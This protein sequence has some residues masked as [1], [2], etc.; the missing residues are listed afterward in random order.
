MEE[1]PH[2]ITVIDGV[3]DDMCTFEE[4]YECYLEAR[5]QKRYRK[6]VMEFTDRLEPNLFEIK[7]ELESQTYK[8]GKYSTFFIKDPKTRLIMSLKFK[9]RIVQWAIYRKLM[10]VY[11]KIFIDD[12][13]ACRKGKG[14]HKAAA[15]LQ[16]WLK[17]ASRK[18]GDW[19]ILKLDISKYF[20]RIDHAVLL[21][22][23]K[24]RIKDER[25]LWLL[26]QIIDNEN[27]RFG[28]PPGMGPEECPPEKR[29]A[30]RGMPIGNLTS[31]LFSNVYLNE[32]DQY[33][34]HTL[35][36]KCYERFADDI[37]IV[38]EDKKRLAYY[39]DSISTFLKERLHLDLNK[40]KTIIC[41][42]SHGVE[43]VGFRVYATHIKLKKQT[44]R[45][46][47]RREKAMNRGISEGTFSIE[48][49][50]RVTASSNGLMLYCNSYG[51]RR[52]INEIRKGAAVNG[53]SENT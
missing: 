45:R 39:R 26:K 17:M 15:R 10:P 41:P 25:L 34:K 22:I 48:K 44:A 23:L 7:R 8:V 47:I 46:M 2:E 21:D 1:R 24:Q 40:R 9:D 28:L 16:Y 20:Y 18:Q 35:K 27:M 50:R 12:S 5:R 6:D 19:Y 42:V 33:C 43:F 38:G 3:Y 53:N 37:I 52:R 13:Y 30:E 49:Y 51:L 4:L 29:L 31:Q 14:I 32:L 11:D 36:I